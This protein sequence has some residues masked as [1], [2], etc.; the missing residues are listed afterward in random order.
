MFGFDGTD[1]TIPLGELLAGELFDF[2][3]GGVA[4][5]RVVGIDLAA[6]LDPLNPVAFVTGLTFVDEGQVN[7][8]QTPLTFN[9]DA[10]PEPSSMAMLLLPGAILLAA[11][12]RRR[13]RTA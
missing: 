8:T 3:T 9:T 10:V 7:M 1:F 11:A 12:R 5:F 2:G 4:A 6:L 13:S